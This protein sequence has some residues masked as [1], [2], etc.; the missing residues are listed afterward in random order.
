MTRFGFV[1]TDGLEVPLPVRL[2]IVKGAVQRHTV[3]P[4]RVLHERIPTHT[5]DERVR[6]PE[7]TTPTGKQ[8]RDGRTFQVASSKPRRTLVKR[9]WPDHRLNPR[10]TVAPLDHP[11]RPAVFRAF[12]F[13]NV[14]PSRRPRIPRV[15]LATHYILP[16]LLQT[17]VSVPSRRRTPLRRAG[18]HM[19]SA[20]DRQTFTSP[21]SVISLDMSPISP[22]LPANAH[23]IPDQMQVAPSAFQDQR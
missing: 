10:R 13:R 11:H 23:L 7:Y 1:L 19:H 12:D 4:R 18:A 22:F 17:R 9:Q 15:A 6:G 5:I 16:C 20:I 8:V 3:I 14:V 21:L 2:R